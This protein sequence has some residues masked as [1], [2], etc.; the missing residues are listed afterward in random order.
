MSH[1]NPTMDYTEDT[2]GAIPDLKDVEETE[3]EELM[4]DDSDEVDKDGL[5]DFERD[6][7]EEHFAPTDGPDNFGGVGW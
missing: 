3:D 7:L 1:P 5:N 6:R 2:N 4:D